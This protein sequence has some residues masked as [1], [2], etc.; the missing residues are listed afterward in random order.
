MAEA[1]RKRYAALRK[2]SAGQ[3]GGASKPAGKKRKMTA[4]GRARI[5]EAARKRW[6]A[7]RSR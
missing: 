7:V 5:A 3:A 1:Q 6:A 2:A 4:K